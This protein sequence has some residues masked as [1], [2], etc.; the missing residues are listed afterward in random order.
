MF[1]M[2]EVSAKRCLVNHERIEIL[3]PRG[4]VNLP[5][6]IIYMILITDQLFQRYPR[7][8]RYLMVDMSFPKMRRIM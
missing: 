1:Q 8:F 2:F 4:A 5:I 7:S 6:P 3:K